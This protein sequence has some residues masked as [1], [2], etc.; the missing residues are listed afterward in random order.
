MALIRPNP[1][2]PNAKVY[3]AILWAV[4]IGAVVAHYVWG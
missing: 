4:V 1:N 2:T 3:G